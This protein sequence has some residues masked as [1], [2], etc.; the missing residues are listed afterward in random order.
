MS[1]ITKISTDTGIVELSPDIV[2]NNLAAGANI[3]NEEIHNFIQ[4]CIFRRLNPFLGQAH[5]VKFG[6]KN[7]KAQLITSKDVFISRMN[8]HPKCKGWNSGIIVLNKQ[9]EIIERIGTFFLK[10]TEKLVGAWF[11]AN[12]DGWETKSEHTINF[13]DYYRTYEKDGKTK[14]MGQWG[15]MPAVMLEKCVIVAGI[16]KTFPE[17]FGGMYTEDELGIPE[18]VVDANFT[19]VEPKKENLLGDEK[20]KNKMQQLC[21]AAKSKKVDFDSSKLLDYAMEQL[22]KS[23]NLKEKSKRRIPMDKFEFVLNYIKTLVAKKEKLS[24]EKEKEE[25]LKKADE[26]IF[27][28][29]DDGLPVKN[30][31]FAT[32]VQE[33]RKNENK[34]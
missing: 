2:R 8:N 7:A 13:V 23:G 24:V 25:K 27:S 19:V 12:I 6:G 30:D 10:D 31:N 20:N 5:I 26:E 32:P 18:N 33:V 14:A 21:I 29:N 16:R 22:V 34:K 15:I 11:K 9:H 4:L 1:K 28:N 17:E 3:T